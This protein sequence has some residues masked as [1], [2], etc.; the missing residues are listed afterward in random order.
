MVIA[1]ALAHGSLA[2]ESSGGGNAL[3]IILAVAVLLGLAYLA[4][5]KWRRRTPNRDSGISLE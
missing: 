4:Y 2:N 5:K 3:L 1:R